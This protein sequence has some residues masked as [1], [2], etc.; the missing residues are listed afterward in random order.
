VQL[1][2]VYPGVLVGVP[3]GKPSGIFVLDIDSVKHPEADEWLERYAPYIPDTR[4]HRTQ[5]GGLHLLFRHRD[6][7]R[8][9]EGKLHKGVD[10]RG[11][12]G[13]IVWWPAF[14]LQAEDMLEHLA[15]VP[16]WLVDELI[17][18][19]PPA[20]ATAKVSA[21]PPI[22][23]GPFRSK[24]DLNPIIQTIVFAREGQRN[25]ITFWGA[26]RLAEH[27]RAGHIARHSAIEI[28]VE[29]ASRNGLPRAE[30]HRT[31]LSAFRQIGI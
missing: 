31:A 6:G 15:E 29:A 17:E 21:F 20:A 30:A 26:C 4:Q 27:V 12:G 19:A 7:L 2:R 24:R 13:Y 16:Q 18:P 5:S 1:W 23:P 8:N 28:V 3:T 9:S 10:T 11:E 22:K 25:S 14:V